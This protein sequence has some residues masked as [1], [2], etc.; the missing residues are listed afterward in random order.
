MS[1]IREAEAVEVWDANIRALVL[2]LLMSPTSELNF[3]STVLGYLA[4]ASLCSIGQQ[5]ISFLCKRVDCTSIGI[6]KLK[7]LRIYWSFVLT[8]QMS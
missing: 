6:Q 2:Y 1:V 7:L 5:K 4:L 8:T 3:S